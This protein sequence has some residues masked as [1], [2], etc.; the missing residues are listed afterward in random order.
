MIANLVA[1]NLGTDSPQF[2]LMQITVGDACDFISEAEA[3]VGSLESDDRFGPIS[4]L[5]FCK[6]IPSRNSSIKDVVAR[7]GIKKCT[8][9]GVRNELNYGMEQWAE[10]RRLHDQAIDIALEAIPELQDFLMDAM[11][12]ELAK[13]NQFAATYESQ[14]ESHVRQ[15]MDLVTF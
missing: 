14:N 9:D 15:S 2:K 3:Q 1:T 12:E 5:L 4:S 7:I 6:L 8:I 11:P 10:L 13:L